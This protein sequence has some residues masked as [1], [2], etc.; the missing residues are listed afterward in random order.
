MEKYKSIEILEE[1]FGLPAKAI[2]T[3]ED[4]NKQEISGEELWKVLYAFATQEGYETSYE[5]I[6]NSSKVI[7][8]EEEKVETVETVEEVKTEEKEEKKVTPVIVGVSETKKETSKKEKKPK[9]KSALRIGAGIVAIMVGVGGI[10]YVLIDYFSNKKGSS[11]NNGKSKNP[12]VQMIDYPVDEYNGLTARIKIIDEKDETVKNEL[13]G[14]TVGKTQSKEELEEFLS[15][16]EALAWTNVTNV[17]NFING[18][19]LTGDIY[20]TDF[21]SVYDINTV[22]YAAVQYFNELRNN[23]MV[24]AYNDKNV[25]DTKNAVTDFNKRFVRFVF[26]DAKLGYKRINA[27]YTWDDLSPSAQN[28]IL[29]MGMGILTIEHDFTITVNG[30]KYNRLFTGEEAFKLK[31]EVY[32]NV[33]EQQQFYKKNSK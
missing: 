33:L 28:T 24:A 5:F 8:K 7:Q 13:I 26:D 3:Y 16:Q 2:V 18:K 17:S 6:K 31:Q 25:E 1:N 21:K 10:S 12:Y 19:E 4:E 32:N 20:D 22:D 23:I 15:N 27:N 30:E 9:K 11:D 29:A 14:V